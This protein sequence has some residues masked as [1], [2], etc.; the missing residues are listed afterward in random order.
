MHKPAKGTKGYLLYG[1]DHK[2]FFRVYDP[3]DKSKFTDY[4]LAF[5]D[6]EI[7]IE[8]RFCSLYTEED[9]E[10]NKL[11]YSPRVLGNKE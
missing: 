2:Y 6:L 5:E 3:E 1:M 4:K 10:K 7:T 9:Q 11:G 8:D